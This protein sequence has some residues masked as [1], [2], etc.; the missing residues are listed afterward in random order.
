MCSQLLIVSIY[1]EGVM[2]FRLVHTCIAEGVLAAQDRKSR[3][4]AESRGNLHSQY[5]L[6]ITILREVG[7]ILIIA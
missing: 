5:E 6:I 2:V 4:T 7:K 3:N 1:I